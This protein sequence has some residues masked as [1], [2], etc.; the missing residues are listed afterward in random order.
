MSARSTAIAAAKSCYNGCM[1][2]D[3]ETILAVGVFV[4]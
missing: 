1:S 2:Y 4:L 3:L